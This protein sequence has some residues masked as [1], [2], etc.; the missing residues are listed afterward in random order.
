[1]ASTTIYNNA[2]L[3]LVRGGISFP[4]SLASS[5]S[6]YKLMLVS[7]TSTYSPVKS[8]TTLTD[9]TGNGGSEASGTGYTAGGAFPATIAT[10]VDNS[11]NFASVTPADVS[12][13]SSTI[14]AKGAIL[15]A[16]SGNKMVAFIDFGGTVSSA[17]STFTVSFTTP[18]KLQ[19]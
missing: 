18:L 10:A 7:S 2:L 4:S 9:F 17:N 13:A 12:W 3:E 1:M 6:T 15:Y 8:H 16:V 5:N 19:N 14:S 11:L